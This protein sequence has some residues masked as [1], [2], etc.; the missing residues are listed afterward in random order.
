M[1]LWRRDRTEVRP[2][3]L[4]L[5]EP[6]PLIREGA[7]GGLPDTW[8][9]LQATHECFFFVADWHA[10]TTDYADTSRVK[11]NI[12]EMAFDWFAAFAAYQAGFTLMLAW[13]V[14]SLAL[15]AFVR[16]THCRQLS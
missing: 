4:L 3:L 16:E 6:V 8:R 15:L 10:L 5:V 1:R 14:L 2:V 11:S 7:F 13:G 12:L 9:A